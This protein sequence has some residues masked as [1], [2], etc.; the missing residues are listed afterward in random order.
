MSELFPAVSPAE[1]V[2]QA[3]GVQ[4]PL[5][6]LGG[7]RRNPWIGRIT[8]LVAIALL[9]ALPT[10]LDDPTRTRQWAEYLCYAAL[11]IGIDIAWGYGGMLV[12]GQ[13]LFFGLGAYAMG[14]HLTLEQVGPGQLPSFMSLYGDQT[15]L[16]LVWK[17]FEHLWVTV[18]LAL[19]VPMA[20]A[21]AFG[22]LVFSRRVRGPYFA[23]LSQAMALIFTLIMVGQL[24][25]F[26]GTNGLTDFQTVFGRNKY[27][28]ST[29]TF[30]YFVA[31]GLLVVVFLVALH[32]VRSR[33]GRLLLAVRDREDRV[34]FLGYNPAVAKTF[35]FV[36]AAAMAGAAGA[37]AAPVIGIVAPNQFG[38]L[39]SILMVCWVAVGGR[40][41]LYGA[42]LGAIL[43]NWGST[44]VSEQWPDTWQY[45]QGLV[46]IVVVAFIPGGLVGLARLLG[47]RFVRRQ[48]AASTA[49]VA[50]EPAATQ[51]GLVAT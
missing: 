40:G 30:L 28:P 26:A 19:V 29:N 37:V 6:Y 8:F 3:T 2:P 14:M 10:I 9:A 20:L 11:A 35:G 48:T 27:E 50:A 38:T 34:R 5:S 15:E 12:L 31:A 33:Y 21:G 4:T 7:S 13:G 1:T 25:T 18:V 45:V 46:F 23:L 51:E 32:L 22:W 42:V 47:G 16:P 17:P 36:V 39:P 49:A 24:K 43:V 44:R 41:T